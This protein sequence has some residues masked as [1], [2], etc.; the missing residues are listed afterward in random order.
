MEAKPDNP[1]L[2][3]HPRDA[4]LQ[5]RIYGGFG[6]P[7]ELV[8]ITPQLRKRLRRQVVTAGDHLAASFSDYPAIPAVLR[9]RLRTEAMAKSHRPMELLNRV[10]MPPVGTHHFGE[11]LLPATAASLQHLSL[12]IIE[13]KAKQIRANISAIE[14]F[15]AFTSADA[16]RMTEGDNDMEKLRAWI[17]AKK[18]LVLE[19][20]TN[21][22]PDTDAAILDAIDKALRD[23]R[24]K[25]LGEPLRAS[26][27]TA[28]IIAAP[29]VEAALAIAACPGVR[30]LVPAPEVAP[31]KLTAQWFNEVRAA[32]LGDLP[33]PVADLPVVAVVDTGVAAGEPLLKLWVTKRE[34]FL[35]GADADQLHGTFVSGLIAGARTLNGGNTAFPG[36]RAL[37]LD[38]TALGSGKNATGAYDI[39]DRIKTAL[40]R[41]PAVKV[42]N[43][44]FNVPKAGDPQL[45]GY[46]A[47]ELDALSDE[48][49]VLF[50]ISAGNFKASPMRGWPNPPDYGGEDRIGEPAEAVRALTVGSV[51]HLPALVQAGDPSPFSRRGPGP[52]KTPKPDLTHNGGNCD[53]TSA[54][55]GAGVFSL[56]PGKRMA[57]S[58]GTSFSAPLASALTANVWQTLERQGFDVRPEMVKALTIHAAALDAPARTPEERHYHGFGVPTSVMET[59]FC[60][61]DTF[62]LLFDAEVLDSM[63]WEKTPFPIPA[64]LHPNGTHFRGEITLTLVYSPPL[65]GR[66]GAEYVRANINAHFGTYD[67]D[68][69]GELKFKGIVP[70][71]T[72]DKRD[73][74]EEAMIDHGFKWSPVKVYRARFARGK[75]G[76]TFRLSLDLL[77]RAGEPSRRD[78][79]RAV[80]IVSFRALE[81]D[82]PVYNDGIRALRATNWTT[83]K[84]ATATHLRT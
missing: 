17:A 3:V 29:T 54:F 74:Y 37:I 34:P 20:F 69:D 30:A 71:A 27:H 15:E 49:G 2:F 23:T 58:I 21:P 9:L 13:S 59:L 81:D 25:S 42:W 44:S 43:C 67:P 83:T 78:P 75:A 66:H 47:S 82:Q 33:A 48:F 52:A 84:A 16:L 39:I 22:D 6:D 19:R 31:I 35:L 65:D 14:A 62:T 5:Q 7:V 70:L 32:T 73:L 60:R 68:K 61:P 46:L 18:P 50:V 79:Q 36:E 45:F 40:R 24:A 53:A 4:D 41:N 28:R 76:H 56:L 57:E 12:M 10:G 51:A 11:L 8:P 64:C 77:R 72:P 26:F 38:V 55:G 80:V 63:V 1:L